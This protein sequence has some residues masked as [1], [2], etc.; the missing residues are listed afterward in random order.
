MTVPASDACHYLGQAENDPLIWASKLNTRLSYGLRNAIGGEVGGV[1]AALLLGNRSW[2]SEDTVL[3]F[4]RAGVSHLLAL[5]GL[6][7]SIL[8]GFLE[9]VFRKLKLP[10]TARAVT[11]PLFA[12]GYLALSG[13]AVSTWRAVL[14]IC[15]LYL[16]Y[17]FRADY[18]AFTALSLTLALI[19]AVTPYAVLDLSL[20]MSFLAAG[21][22]IV[23]SPAVSSFLWRWKRRTR[24][25]APLFR[26]LSAIASAFAVGA[27]L[28]FRYHF[29]FFVHT[30]WQEVMLWPIGKKY[31][32]VWRPTS[33]RSA[34]G[35]VRTV[36]CWNIGLHRP[37][38][39]AVGWN[40]A[41]FALT[42]W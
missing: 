13:F 7:V 5:S 12:L 30:I 29:P 19:L 31:P 18:D 33:K 38:I 20:W 10:H 23:F 11:V 34:A 2:L 8:I 41:C 26:V 40:A 21:S 37:N 3:A 25:P 15:V 22:I 35:S 6:H 14:M 24:L 32:V 36:R 4:R 1:G 17:L 27:F 16:A 28:C 42:A 39:E 9:L